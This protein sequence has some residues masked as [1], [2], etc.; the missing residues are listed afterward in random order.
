MKLPRINTLYIGII[1]SIL[2]HIAL[3]WLIR[4][5][6]PESPT[7]VKYEVSLFYYFPFPQ[8]VVR[9]SDKP[10]IK[11]KSIKKLDQK[12][13]EPPLPEEHMVDM[14]EKERALEK[15]DVNALEPARETG[16]IH[17]E[18]E[19]VQSGQPE[20]SEYVYSV[21]EELDQ[22]G[23]N[24]LGKSKLSAS[25][26]PPVDYSDLLEGLR[27]RILSE[28]VYPPQARRRG[29]EGIVHLLISLDPSGRLIE[30]RVV[31][32][33]GHR[34]LD[35]AAVSLIKRVLPYEHGLG[36]PVTFEISIRYELVD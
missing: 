31:R 24:I 13:E 22:E 11:K 30:V 14:A 2:I 8:E 20:V 29:I 27:Q 36:K 4:R 7:P 34:M 3:L 16:E 17:E 35:N 28:R 26:A 21:T 15:V 23:G 10:S 33:S 32:S 25:T 1:I 5:E 6:T 9:A 18:D 12:A 19:L